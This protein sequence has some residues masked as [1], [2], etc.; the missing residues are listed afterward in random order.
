[1]QG[2]EDWLWECC[3][4]T[5]DQIVIS[6]P[7]SIECNYQVEMNFIAEWKLE[8]TRQTEC[9]WNLSLHAIVPLYP[10]WQTAHVHFITVCVWYWITHSECWHLVRLPLEPAP[11]WITD[12]DVVKVFFRS[13]NDTAYMG[14]TTDRNV[15][16]GNLYSANTTGYVIIITK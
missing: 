11:V 2:L 4:C 8:L 5:R 16:G 1:M 3:V 9:V 6:M 15:N 7:V 13:E 14:I 10:E 12:L